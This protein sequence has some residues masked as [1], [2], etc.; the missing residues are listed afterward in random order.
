MII[1][2]SYNI[3]NLLIFMVEIAKFIQQLSLLFFL[4]QTFGWQV[5]QSKD[6][7]LRD[8]GQLLIKDSSIKFDIPLKLKHSNNN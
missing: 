1:Y 5:L 4:Q 7:H 8:F 3:G 6:I 2:L